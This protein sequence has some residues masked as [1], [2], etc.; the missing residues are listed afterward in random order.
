MMMILMVKQR[1]L[2]A[3][4]QFFGHSSLRLV[5]TLPNPIVLISLF[6]WAMY[7][8]MHVQNMYV[9]NRIEF[10]FVN[11]VKICVLDIVVASFNTSWSLG[12]RVVL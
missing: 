9:H 5:A 4:K 1:R 6:C 7:V 10:I 12:E 2:R 8:C 11:E 3:S